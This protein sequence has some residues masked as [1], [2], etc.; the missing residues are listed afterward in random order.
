MKKDSEKGSKNKSKKSSVGKKILK[1]VGII[2]LIPILIVGGFLA[3]LTIKEYRPADVEAVEVDTTEGKGEKLVSGTEFTVMSWNMGYAGLGDNMDFFMDGGSGET[4]TTIERQDVNIAG[5]TG[6]MA[7]NNPDVLFLQEI[8]RN[9]DR[10]YNVDELFKVK[11]DLTTYENSMDPENVPYASTFA[12][13]YNAEY[14]PYPVN[15]MIGHVESGVAVLSKYEIANA[16]RVSL[17][18]PFSWPVKT[19]N[20]KRCL[21]V[22][23]VPVVDAEG[24]DTGKE[25][26]L[27]N[28]HLEAYDDGEGKIAQTKALK[29]L[30]DEELNKGNYV[31]VGGDFNQTF[32]NVDSSMYPVKD[33]MWTPG[34]LDTEEFGSRWQCLMDNT[35][36]TCRS[37]DQPYQG[38]D[39]DNF[40]YYMIDGFI[41]SDNVKVESVETLDYYFAGSDHNPVLL[42]VSL[43]E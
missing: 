13:N 35:T 36:P 14:V 6:M 39:Q 38:A 20:L 28:L 5:L 21:L 25:L 18:C 11:G 37:L 12:Y 34:S 24:N 26:V 10:T 19:V 33:G 3:W 40:Q 32:S 8:D 41:V 31:I 7:A 27:I 42:K 29:K 43:G 1:I 17:P 2:L 30:M 15:D 4:V 16:E 9:S 22:N 23:H